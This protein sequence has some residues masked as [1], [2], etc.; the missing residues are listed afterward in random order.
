MRGSSRIP[1]AAI[2]F[3][4]HVDVDPRLDLGTGAGAGAGAL[5]WPGQLTLLCFHKQLS[6]IF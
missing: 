3:D 1:G 4:D 6:A 5:K 2:Q